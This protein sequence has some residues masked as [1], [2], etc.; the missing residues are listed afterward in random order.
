MR[1]IPMVVIATLF[2]SL[3]ESLLI[4]PAHLAHTRAISKGEAGQGLSGSWK[5][6]QRGFSRRLQAFVETKYQPSLDFILK[7]RYTF[8]AACLGLLLITAGLVRG[9]FIR[10]T[11]F[12]PVEGG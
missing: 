5:R 1:V 9:G 8:M 12:P 3:V 6:F 11:F 4:L 2:F 7:W 10:F